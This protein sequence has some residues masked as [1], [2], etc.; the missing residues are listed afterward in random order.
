MKVILIAMLLF[1]LGLAIELQEFHAVWDRESTETRS[2]GYTI[3]NYR[4]LNKSLQIKTSQYDRC[5]D[6]NDMLEYFRDNGYDDD[7]VEQV[8]T[9][10]REFFDKRCGTDVRKHRR[11]VAESVRAGLLVDAHVPQNVEAQK[12]RDIPIGVPS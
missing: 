4:K 12:A 7:I 2:N 11:E 3:T 5:R 9:H 6:V 10:K 8:R 1:G